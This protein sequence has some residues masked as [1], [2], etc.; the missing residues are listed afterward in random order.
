MKDFV[1]VLSCVLWN[2]CILVTT[3]II[4]TNSYV[5]KSALRWKGLAVE[6]CGEV[7]YKIAYRTNSSICVLLSVRPLCCEQ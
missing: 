4:F 3:L 6:P 2:L 1:N 5:V 7:T